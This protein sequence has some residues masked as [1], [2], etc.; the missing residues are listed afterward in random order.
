[1]A[2]CACWDRATSRC[3][4]PAWASRPPANCWWARPRAISRLL[5]P[6]RTVRSIKRKMGSAETVPLGD[7]TFTPQE[8]SA[9]ILRELA[10][11][12]RPRLEAAGRNAPSSPC[13]PISPTRSATPRARPARWPGW[14]WCAFSTSP[15][16]PAWPTA[17]A[18][19]RAAPSWSTI[20]A[21]APSTS[22]WSPMEGDV[23]E[24]L[25]S[26]GN[27]HLGGDD[28]DDLLLRAAGSASSRSSTASICATDTPLAHGA[29]VVGRRRSQEEA[30]LRAL[31]A[32]PRRGPGHRRTA[33]RCIWTWSCRATEY[34]KMIR[35]LVESTLD[36]V[37]KALED[38]GKKP[39]DLDAILLVGGSTRTPL[40]SRLLRERTGL[41][42]RAGRASGSVRGAGRGRAG[43]A[44]G[45][46]RCGA[47]AGGCV[48]VFLRPVLPGRA[49]RRALSALLPPHHPPQYA[50]AGDAHGELLH[51]LSGTDARW[52]SR[53]FRATT[54]TR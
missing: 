35:P 38:A 3:C 6:E 50:A 11:W 40:V 13:P 7:K 24:V 20:W 12:A 5:Y 23:T 46:A 9:L 44:P 39:R 53:S 34:E 21:A 19:A 49:R 2:R 17:S 16:P 54:K 52:T 10:E 15:P 28:F 30:E 42:P 48:A 27:N 51:H 43:L 18:T 32:G 8:I 33:S 26:H 31:R 29:P 41:E 36:S 22:P 14:R 37:S 47:R 4:P 25:A 1:M 45:G